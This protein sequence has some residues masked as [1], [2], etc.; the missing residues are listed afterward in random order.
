MS[1]PVVLVVG[2]V[3]LLTAAFVLPIADWITSLFA[4]IDANRT[5]SWIVFILMYVA[6]AVLLLPGSLLTLGAGFLFGLGYG[7]VIVSAASVLGAS[8]AFLV[9]RFLARD[10]VSDKLDAMP[11]FAAL[12][13]AIEQRG[14]L[15][16]LLTRLSPVFP[17][18]LLNYAL[19]LTAVRFWTYVGAS[20]IGMMPG[21]VLYVYLGSVASDLASLLAGDLAESPVGN[22][23]F[24]VGLVATVVLTVVITRIA[25]KALSEQLEQ[26]EA[27]DPAAS[28][29]DAEQSSS[30]EKGNAAV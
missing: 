21:T 7:F 28:D 12:D 23:L 30:Q 1:K 6:A 17:F 24:Y 5:V 27:A 19:G 9:G 20:W 3:V 15:I 16:V 13:R 14:G 18:N 11:R 25:G 8:C 2:L 4:W 26:A 29:P 10:W 22:S